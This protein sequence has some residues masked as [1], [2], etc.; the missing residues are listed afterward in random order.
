MYRKIS[1]DVKVAAVR[2]YERQLLSLDDILDSC[3]FSERTWYRVLKLWRH[4]G[5]VVPPNSSLRGR[6]CL[7]DHDDVHYLI[8]LICQNPE[9]FLDELLY[10]LRTRRTDSSPSTIQ[11]SIENWSALESA[12]KSSSAL[13]RNGTKS[14]MQILSAAWHDILRRSLGLLTRY[15]KMKGLSEGGMGGPGRGKGPKRSK[16]LCAAIALPQKPC[17]HWTGSSQR[18]WLKVL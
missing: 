9:Y 13:Q 18:R 11:Q 3:G 7:I 2:L 4:T 10:L 6:L 16:S 8:C 12:G 14:A 15:R 17:L 1:R 5:D